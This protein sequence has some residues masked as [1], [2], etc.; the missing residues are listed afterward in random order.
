MRNLTLLTDLYQLTM[1]NAYLE[2]DKAD[3]MA[4]FDIFFR[5][6]EHLD[7][8]Q[9]AGLEQVIEYINNLHFDEDDIDYLKS[10]NLFGDRFFD[11]IKNF[12]FTGSIRAI[13]EGE[14][15]FPGEPI[16]S[17]CAPL[18]QA[19]L[20]ETA[21]L[22]IINHQTLIATKA[23]KICRE[24][25]A[26][27]ME[28]G[29]RRAQGPDAGIY[30]ARAAIIGG[31]SSTSNVLT[32][33]MYGIACAGTHAHSWVM[34]FD[35][36][37]EAFRAYVKI[38]PK[39]GLLLVDT[40]DTLKS[41]LPNAIKVFDEMKAAGL[42]PVGIRL[43]SGDLAYLSKK[44]R[45]ILDDAGHNDCIIC[46]SGDI[47]EYILSSLHQQGAKIDVYGIGTKL[48]TSSE[49][50]ALGGVY[51]M[52][53]LQEN[54]VWIP[55]MK[56]S[57]TVEKIT[58]PGIKTTYRIYDNENKALADIICLVDEEFDI[59]KPLTIFHPQQTWKKTILNNYT[60]RNLMVD[61]FVDGKQAYTS[62]KLMDI[63]QYAKEKSED[64]YTE[65][66]RLVNPH[67]FKVDLSQKLYDLKND[68]T[69][70][71]ENKKK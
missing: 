16:L 29:L 18:F 70:N 32:S 64:F 13:K 31:C 40:Y 8:A 55:K 60:M 67:T 38:Y 1:M 52:S 46:A 9:C 59:T 26:G 25:Q 17:V 6:K 47:D 36:E 54:G 68:L 44:A 12:K 57:D 21:L 4:N 71:N 49:V 10:L 22:N 66:L 51:K 69:I 28:F 48:I 41:G 58:I 56:F 35:S 63:A 62:P 14:I 50:P 33:K 42:K 2:T 5:Y 30:G 27:V 23:F 39:N 43:D 53:C 3:T 37:L 24:A 34:S 11:A 20:V 7:F 19:Q 65:Y 45:K 61:I 15:I